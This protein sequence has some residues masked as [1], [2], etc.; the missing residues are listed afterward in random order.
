MYSKEITQQELDTFNRE[1]VR[2]L[3]DEGLIIPTSTGW[4]LSGKGVSTISDLD[5]TQITSKAQPILC[6][7]V[8]AYDEGKVA[9]L[10]RQRQPFINFIG[11]PGGKVDKGTDLTS[12]A[13]E[14]LKEE[15][16]LSA[17]NFE[18]KLIQEAFTYDSNSEELLHHM[19]AFHYLATGITG[20][21]NPL[22]REGEN[23]WSTPDAIAEEMAFPRLKTT[24][25]RM[26][27]ANTLQF[28]RIKRYLDDETF[29]GIHEE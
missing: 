28:Q 11:L 19:I 15:T 5:G 24:I 20:T 29:T 13:R 10:K 9:L 16:G 12:Q 25:K 3:K 23:F 17:E 6:T 4:T 14:E 26:I 8:L 18:L 27:E 21:L 22:T 2:N 1:T 7:F